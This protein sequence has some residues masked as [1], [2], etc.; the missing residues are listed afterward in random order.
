M[1]ID[2]F[3]NY[4]YK[5]SVSVNSKLWDDILKIDCLDDVVDEI[6]IIPK[7]FDGEGET[8]SRIPLEKI[9]MKFI[10]DIA[11]LLLKY[12]KKER[13]DEVISIISCLN[14]I[15]SFIN[16]QEINYFKLDV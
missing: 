13:D 10:G 11:R 14:K 16:N 4:T 9:R 8:L 7:G 3:N 15:L 6:S 5:D 1:D 12:S 2:F